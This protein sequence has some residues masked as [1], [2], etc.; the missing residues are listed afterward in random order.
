MQLLGSGLALSSTVMTVHSVRRNWHF[1][2]GWWTLSGCLSTPEV[3]NEKYSPYFRK[4]HNR[5][6]WIS[7]YAW[8]HWTW[9]SVSTTWSNLLLCCFFYFFHFLF[10]LLGLHQTIS[11][12]TC[13]T[14]DL[15]TL[16]LSLLLRWSSLRS[17]MAFFLLISSSLNVDSLR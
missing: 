7:P 17:I 13:P 9:C 12:P 10:L 2:W 14:S 1:S 16:D 15:R 6:V 8:R 4:Q 3:V 5:K 11:S